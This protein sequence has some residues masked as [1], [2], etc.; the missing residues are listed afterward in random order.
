MYLKYARE[1]YQELRV[2]RKPYFDSTCDWNMQLLPFFFFLRNSL[3]IKPIRQY[4]KKL[5]LKQQIFYA[6]MLLSV[7]DVNSEYLFICL[8]VF[9]LLLF[10]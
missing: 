3:G 4:F 10:F 6:T 5:N 8:G 2:L 9:L 1:M 7:L